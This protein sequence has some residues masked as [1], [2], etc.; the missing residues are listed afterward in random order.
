MEVEDMEDMHDSGDIEDMEKEGM[1][2]TWNLF[3]SFL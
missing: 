1:L 3:W 2:E